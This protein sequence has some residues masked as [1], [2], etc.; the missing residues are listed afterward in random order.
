[1]TVDYH[2]LNQVETAITSAVPDMASY[3]IKSIQTLATGSVIDL[4]VFFSIP[5]NKIQESS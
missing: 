5:T 4:S 3:W 2:Q 1:M